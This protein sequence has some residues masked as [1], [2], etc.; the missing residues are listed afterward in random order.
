MMYGAGK[1]PAPER[2]A[3]QRQD[4]RDAVL[5]AVRNDGRFDP[6]LQVT[7]N[8]GETITGTYVIQL[9]GLLTIRTMFGNRSIMNDQIQRVTGA[10]SLDPRN[11]GRVR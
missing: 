4:I 7:T 8:D 1:A 2:E 6:M 9:P 5:S 11:V 10:V 3:M